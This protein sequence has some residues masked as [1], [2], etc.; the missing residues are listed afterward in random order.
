MTNHRNRDRTRSPQKTTCNAN[1]AGKRIDA[2]SR[3]TYKHTHTHKRTQTHK[4]PRKA[5]EFI[6]LRTYRDPTWRPDTSKRAHTHTYARNHTRAHTRT[7]ERKRAHA[8]TYAHALSIS[9]HSHART[10]ARA[11]ARTHK[12]MI[13]GPKKRLTQ[14]HRGVP[15]RRSHR[16]RR[17]TTTTASSPRPTGA[18]IEKRERRKN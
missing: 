6:H 12:H 9:P 2:A 16:L 3:P 4:T 7:H 8:S 14:T 1:A 15:G 18:I 11:Q 17:F 10:H 13:I 5:C